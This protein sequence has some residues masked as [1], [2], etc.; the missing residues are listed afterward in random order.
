M[1]VA[2]LTFGPAPGTELLLA[3][4]AAQWPVLVSTAAGVRTSRRLVRRRADA[5]ALPAATM[6]KIVVPAAAPAWLVGARL[7][8]IIALLV[9]IVVEMVLSPRGLGGGLVQAMQALNV[10]ADVGVRAGRAASSARRQCGLRRL[11]A[12]A[13]P[14]G[15]IDR[16]VGAR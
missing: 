11:V 15:P 1:P 6:R 12:A 7:A 4:W 3:A 5:A 16:P 2:V 9:T 8:L 14:G 13:L 10:D